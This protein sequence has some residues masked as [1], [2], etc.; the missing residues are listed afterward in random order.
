MSSIN[1]E[2]PREDAKNL[3][4]LAFEN[5]RGIKTY[6][7]NGLKII[8]KTGASLG[9]YGEKVIV[10]IPEN[11]AGDEQTM[12]SIRSEKE[13]GMNITANPDKYE[14]RFLTELNNL[15]GKPIDELLAEHTESVTEEST[16]EVESANE[17]ADGTNMLYVVLAISFVMIFFFMLMPLMML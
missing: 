13:V 6:N 7:D 5:T 12:V 4:K 14:S 11:Q 16:K 3:V 10:D 15:R 8:G 9:S 17:Q 1:L 2:Y